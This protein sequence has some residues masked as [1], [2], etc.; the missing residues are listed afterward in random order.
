MIARGQPKDIAHMF[1]G[2][3]DGKPMKRLCRGYMQRMDMSQS[4]HDIREIG[5]PS[6]IAMPIGPTTLTLTILVH[7]ELRKEAIEMMRSGEVDIIIRGT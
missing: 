3:D 6:A 1:Y 5:A 7:G 4:Q 2:P